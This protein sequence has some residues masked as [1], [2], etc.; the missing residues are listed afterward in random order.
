M[1]KKRK[2]RIETEL[3]NYVLSE[4]IDPLAGANKYNDCVIPYNFNEALNHIYSK[5]GVFKH[6]FSFTKQKLQDHLLQEETHYYRSKRDGIHKEG[7][8]GHDKHI[9]SILNQYL[10]IKKEDYKKYDNVNLNVLLLKFDHD[11]HNDEKD[12]AKVQD[13]LIST[14]FED[15]YKE[16]STSLSGEHGYV[17]LAYP[18]DLSIEYVCDVIKQVFALLDKKRQLLGYSSPIDVPCGLPN[19][20][21]WDN[22]ISVDTAMPNIT[23]KEYLR[24]RNMKKSI[25]ASEIAE[26]DAL[27]KKMSYQYTYSD[28]KNI[29]SI[30]VPCSIKQ[31][32]CGKVPRFI[33][34]DAPYSP[35]IDNIVSFYRLRY[36][37]LSSLI[38]L[39][40]SLSKDNGGPEGPAL[41]VGQDLK[42]Q[43]DLPRLHSP[44]TP[45]QNSTAPPVRVERREEE[46][47]VCNIV[48]PPQGD[49][50]IAEKDYLE[51]INTKTRHIDN[52][53]ARVNSFYYYYSEYLGHIPLEDEAEKEYIILGLNRSESRE[54][55]Q[56]RFKDGRIW[57]ESVIQI[58]KKGFRLLDWDKNREPMINMI[59]A[60]MNTEDRYWYKGKKR[61]NLKAEDFALI[62]YAVIKSNEADDRRSKSSKNYAFSYRQGQD[63]FR[64]SHNKGCH[65][66]KISTILKVLKESELIELVGDYQIGS[67]GN[68]YKA[69]KIA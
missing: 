63:V 64:A 43:G 24:Y 55:R 11:G 52:N 16:P 10:G 46:E 8:G 17:K 51:M 28:I 67:H 62:Y 3:A 34:R 7:Y 32:Q 61:Y 26:S 47:V 58:A 30:P 27:S 12:S 60:H 18:S 50:E 13:W 31:S 65:R 36:Y 42:G 48:R 54:G 56:R 1:N 38:S 9:L 40:S 44:N 22:S 45:C 57:V 37:H 14:Y 23:Y 25:I 19:L 35:S 68:K 41:T 20:I 33:T 53:A 66:N 49:R 29:L 21:T 4:F 5:T 69:K 59:K 2:Y 15:T 6:P 39:L